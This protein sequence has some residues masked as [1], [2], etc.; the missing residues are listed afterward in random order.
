MMLF[1]WL[2]LAVVTWCALVAWSSNGTIDDD[3]ERERQSPSGSP[4]RLQSFCTEIVSH[5]DHQQLRLI[6]PLSYHF[7]LIATSSYR[8]CFDS[9]AKTL[10]APGRTG[11][12]RKMSQSDF[13]PKFRPWIFHQIS[14]SFSSI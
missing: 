5:C 8:S 7:Y 6:L 12:T 13:L 14:S 2:M 4:S 3:D 10:G 1:L 9:H 11:F